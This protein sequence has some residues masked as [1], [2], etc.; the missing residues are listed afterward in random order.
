[1]CDVENC[2]L[3]IEN[4]VGEITAYSHTRHVECLLLGIASILKFIVSSLLTV[5]F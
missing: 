3:N 5:Q 4:Q 2:S 1:M